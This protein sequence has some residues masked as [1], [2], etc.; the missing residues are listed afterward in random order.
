MLHYTIKVLNFSVLRMMGSLII[1]SKGVSLFLGWQHCN[2]LNLFSIL[3]GDLKYTNY[4][5]KL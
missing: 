3:V 1:V 4:W 5:G 2:L